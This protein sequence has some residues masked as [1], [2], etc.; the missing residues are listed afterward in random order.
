MKLFD[1]LKI[2]KP[3][4]KIQ[5]LTEDD[6]VLLA[7]GQF[8]DGAIG[9]SKIHD[10]VFLLT[11]NE[12]FSMYFDKFKFEEKGDHAYSD[13]IHRY[14]KYNSKNMNN[15]SLITSFETEEKTQPIVVDELR[16]QLY[17]NVKKVEEDFS[18]GMLDY[19]PKVFYLSMAG[20]LLSM[21]AIKERMTNSQRAILRECFN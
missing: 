8:K 16:L 12:E 2:Q 19:S 21:A 6:F 5:P 10:L 1:R 17:D 18:Q 15:Q 7:I 4:Q 11:S 20:K 3:E 9:E 14:L 13:I